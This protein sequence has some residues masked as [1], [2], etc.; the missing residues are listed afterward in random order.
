V[1]KAFAVRPAVHCQVL[2][3]AVFRVVF[4]PERGSALLEHATPIGSDFLQH[5]VGF[6]HGA[7]G[8]QFVETHVGRGN[9]QDTVVKDDPLFDPFLLRFVQ[10]IEKDGEHVGVTGHGRILLAI[11][12][13]V[14][15]GLLVG[16]PE[17]GHEA[18]PDPVGQLLVAGLFSGFF[19]QVG[20]QGHGFQAAAEKQL[21]EADLPFFLQIAVGP[22]NKYPVAGLAFQQATVVATAQDI[23]HQAHH[24]GIHQGDKVLVT[25]VL[26]IVVEADKPIHGVVHDG[27]EVTGHRILPPEVL[28]GTLHSGIIVKEVIVHQVALAGIARPGPAVTFDAV[29]KELSGRQVHGIGTHLPDFVEQVVVTAEGA[30]V[31]D[32]AVF[33]EHIELAVAQV[34]RGQYVEVAVRLGLFKH[35]VGWVGLV[36]VQDVEGFTMGGIQGLFHGF[37]VEH[38]ELSL[39]LQPQKAGIAHGLATKIHQ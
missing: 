7:H 22:V 10:V 11:D 3:T 1:T 36:N 18:F 24:T 32:R 26:I 5:V 33:V 38:T 27:V 30:L 35:Q 28:H 39:T 25:G 12:P 20:A 21:F 29:D 14:N 19:E 2:G 9:L 15:E 23:V 34:A 16:V 6:T 17:I 8:F 4:F 13:G 37:T 31:R